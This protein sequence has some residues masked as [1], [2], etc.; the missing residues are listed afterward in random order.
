VC[1]EAVKELLG[2]PFVVCDE[3]VEGQ[4]RKLVYGHVVWEGR[5]GAES[6]LRRHFVIEEKYSTW[7]LEKGGLGRRDMGDSSQKSLLPQAA[8]QSRLCAI[9]K[10]W[11]EEE[12]DTEEDAR[13]SYELRCRSYLRD[14]KIAV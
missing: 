4:T 9:I 14:F 12:T 5:H 6:L 7:S 1:P 11:K 13:P 10:G 2:L 8:L 3:L